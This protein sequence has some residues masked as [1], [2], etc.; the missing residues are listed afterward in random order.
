M[1]VCADASFCSLSTHYIHFHE[2]YSSN[3]NI[4]TDTGI[5]TKY[6]TTQIGGT[7]SVQSVNECVIGSFVCIPLLFLLLFF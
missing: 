3:D 2:D 7:C 1:G 4:N 6:F 5:C